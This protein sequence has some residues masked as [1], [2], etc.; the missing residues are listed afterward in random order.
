MTRW[1]EPKTNNMEISN[2]KNISLVIG[3]ERIECEGVMYTPKD[4]LLTPT[5]KQIVDIFKAKDRHPNTLELLD[6]D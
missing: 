1:N 6:L 4:T 3:G 5:E 2:W